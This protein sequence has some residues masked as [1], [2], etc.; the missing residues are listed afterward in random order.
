MLGYKL[1]FAREGRLFSVEHRCAAEG[2]RARVCV[3]AEERTTQLLLYA[4]RRVRGLVS[5]SRRRKRTP[6]NPREPPLGGGGGA[7]GGG[8]GE[9][10]EDEE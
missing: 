10:V 9:G 6:T 5:E 1:R 4:F 8:R 3:C 2:T 7:G